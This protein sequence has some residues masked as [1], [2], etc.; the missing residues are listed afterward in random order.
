M[1]ENFAMREIK[2]ENRKTTD[3]IDRSLYVTLIV[4]LTLVVMTM[5]SSYTYIKYN[6][7]NLMS[8]N[9]SAAIS[10]GV[11]PLS[12]RCSFAN[13]SDLVCVAFA[14]SNKR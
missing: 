10:K 8:S 14:A 9:I 3:K 1:N 2:R 12:V 11:D 5:I 13:T 4:C 6:D 7:R